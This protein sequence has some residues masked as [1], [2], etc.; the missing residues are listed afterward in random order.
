MLTC[1]YLINRSQGENRRLL[2]ASRQTGPLLNREAGE[3]GKV[4]KKKP[5]KHQAVPAQWRPKPQAGIRA[6]LQESTRQKKKPTQGHA[7]KTQS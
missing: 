2:P 1:L 6:G 5:V 4:M 3:R 7:F